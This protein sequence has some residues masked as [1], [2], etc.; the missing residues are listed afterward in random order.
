MTAREGRPPLNGMIKVLM[1]SFTTNLICGMKVCATT[2]LAQLPCPM[3]IKLISIETLVSQEYGPLSSEALKMYTLKG[4]NVLISSVLMTIFLLSEYR[5]VMII[6]H[7]ATGSQLPPLILQSSL[8][9]E[10]SL[11]PRRHMIQRQ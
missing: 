1:A 10:V 4:C 6:K 7:L 8:T 5:E 2:E 3:A 11:P 9:D